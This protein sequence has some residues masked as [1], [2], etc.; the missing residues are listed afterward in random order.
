MK[1]YFLILLAAML[2]FCVE[3]CASGE[4]QVIVPESKIKYAALTFDDGPYTPV[5]NR[6]LDALEKYNAKATFFV[7]GNRAEIYSQSVRRAYSL[8]CEIGNHTYSHADLCAAEIRTV[9]NEIG[10]C[11]DVIYKIT[12]ERERLFR[13]TGGKNDVTLQSEAGRALILWS[14]DTRDWAHH[15][16]DKTIRAVKENICDGS[17]I[18]MHDLEM[19]SAVCCEKLIP[20]LLEQ[21]YQLVTVSELL[22][23][24]GIEPQAGC[25]YYSA[26]Q[27]RSAIS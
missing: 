19:S 10:K 20:E 22:R 3:G 4:R 5:T 6:I 24:N 9:K 14:I 15:D 18:L 23:L 26:A 16:S 2:L 13:P 27:S 11:S 1:K 17:I 12:G 7:V 8:G 25:K 21:G